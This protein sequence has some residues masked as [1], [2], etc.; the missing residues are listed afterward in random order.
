MKQKSLTNEQFG[1]TAYEYL[2]SPVHAEGADLQRLTKLTKDTNIGT[3]LDLG[4]GAGHASF[5]IAQAAIK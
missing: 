2:I 4:C 3:A 1:N 5:A